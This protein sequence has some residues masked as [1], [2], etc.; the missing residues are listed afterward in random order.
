MKIII[1][2][3]EFVEDV[4]SLGKEI[5]AIDTQI[6]DFLKDKPLTNF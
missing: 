4:D 3:K 2:V 5:S 1:K 6:N